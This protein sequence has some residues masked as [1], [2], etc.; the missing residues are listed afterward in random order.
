LNKRSVILSHSGKQHSYHV[1]QA[2]RNLDVLKTFYTSSYVS[3][4]S[5]QAAVEKFGLNF[6]SKRFLPGLGKPYVNASWKYELKEI[7]YRKIKGNTQKVNELIFDRD[8]QFDRSLSKKISRIDFDTFWGFQGSALQCLRQANEK[9]KNSVCEMTIA[10]LPYAKTILDEEA[11][12]HPEWADSIDFSAFPAQYERRLIEEPHTASKVIAISSFLKET[13]LKDNV[14]GDKISVIPLG[15]DA[16]RITYIREQRPISGR[17]LKLLYAGRVTQRKGM[18]YLLEAMKGFSKSEVELHIIGNVYGS[19]NAFKRYSELYRYS[20]GLSQNE[21]FKIYCNYDALV[22]PSV[23]EGFG[24]VTVEAMG[25]GLPV[26]TTPNTNAAE[27]IRDG[28]N[29][30]LIPVRDAEAIRKAIEKLRNLN[31]RDFQKMREC[32][33]STALQFTWKAHEGHIRDFV[34]K[35]L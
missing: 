29:G 13:L 31:D 6:W 28:E 7:L 23:L 4:L 26:I 1:A 30:F 16:D 11:K 14:S 34:L 9:G 5:L 12:L 10:H 17:T 33:R 3:N 35:N 15:F 20:T 21:L 25:A 32:A 2:L 18:K 19:G 8:I 24:L 22:F 27:L